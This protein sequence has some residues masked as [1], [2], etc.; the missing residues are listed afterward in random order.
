ME[1]SVGIEQRNVSR[2]NTTRANRPPKYGYVVIS[3][4]QEEK[5]GRESG[6]YERNFDAV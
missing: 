3:S 2:V 4:R 1:G 6:S 5:K